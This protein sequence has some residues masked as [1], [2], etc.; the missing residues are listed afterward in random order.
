MDKKTSGSLMHPNSRSKSPKNLGQALVSALVS[1]GISAIVMMVVAQMINDQSVFLKYFT[2]K[3]ETIQLG[4][5]LFQQ[6]NSP[7]VCNWQFANASSGGVINTDDP[8]LTPEISFTKFYAG[9]DA[10]SPVLIDV[11]TTSLSGAKIQSIKFKKFVYTGIPGRYIGD[12]VIALDNTTLVRALP[13]LTLKKIVSVDG[14]AGSSSARPI[15]GCTMTTGPMLI[16]AQD[17]GIQPGGP[18]T[19][20]KTG[21]QACAEVGRACSRVTAFNSIIVDLGCGGGGYYLYTDVYVSV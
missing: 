5:L 11:A 19:P 4:S 15:A 20:A 9:L 10:A 21:T 8:A 2:Q 3:T 7:G 1:L 16:G 17:P 14:A 12:L 6:L 13:A 18:N